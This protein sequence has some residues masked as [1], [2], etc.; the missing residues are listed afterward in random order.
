[1]V[2][3]YLIFLPIQESNLGPLHGNRPASDAVQVRN[4]N[5]AHYA[6]IVTIEIIKKYHTRFL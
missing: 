5:P 2:Y 6:P 1:M 3:I 4:Q